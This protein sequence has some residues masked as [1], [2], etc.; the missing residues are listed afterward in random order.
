MSSTN[1]SCTLFFP[2]TL[3]Q[4]LNKLIHLHSWEEETKQRPPPLGQEGHQRDTH[5]DSWSAY[6]V[7]LHTLLEYLSCQQYGNH[8]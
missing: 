6:V 1:L 7:T 4:S 5:Q 2:K 8:N 3:L